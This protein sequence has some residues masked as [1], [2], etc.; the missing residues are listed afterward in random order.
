VFV[1]DA[2]H[3]LPLY[4][5]LSQCT[6]LYDIDVCSFYARLRPETIGMEIA[7]AISVPECIKKKV[8][9]IL[10]NAIPVPE[11]M[12]IENDSHIHSN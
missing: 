12:L 3:P 11:R 2:P 1:F 4:A 8:G 7:N 5:V 9:M 10:A 6:Q